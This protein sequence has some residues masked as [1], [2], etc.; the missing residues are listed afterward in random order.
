[1]SK[2]DQLVARGLGRYEAIQAVEAGVDP[3]TVHVADPR[4]PAEPR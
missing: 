2:I 4:L 1:M 3:N